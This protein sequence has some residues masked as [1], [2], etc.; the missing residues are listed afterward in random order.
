MIGM[1]VQCLLCPTN[2]IGGVVYAQQIM[3]ID[4]FAFQDYLVQ[5]GI[6]NVI[7]TMNQ[8]Q[9]LS[10]AVEDFYAWQKVSFQVWNKI[11]FPIH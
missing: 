6:L 5:I 1:K 8:R 11:L 3:M 7:L 4:L 10:A 2:V 9:L